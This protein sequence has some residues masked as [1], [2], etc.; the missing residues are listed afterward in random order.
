MSKTPM[1]VAAFAALVLAAT[2][3][4][5]DNE[6]AANPNDGGTRTIEIT[7]LDELRFDPA[8]IEVEV[9]EAIRFVVTNDGATLHDFFVG[10]E[11]EQMEHEEQMQ[12]GMGHDEMEGTGGGMDDHGEMGE[13]LSLESGETR[14]TTHTFDEPGTFLY[15]C[16]QPGHYDGGM[17][18][19]ITVS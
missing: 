8:S 12:G 16:H 1:M 10:D 9:G 17:V 14:E 6:P 11:A 13:A 5:N 3:C 19:T 15:G 7:A 2:A 4:G 18:G